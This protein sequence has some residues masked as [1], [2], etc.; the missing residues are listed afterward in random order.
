MTLCAYIR[1][2]NP[3]PFSIRFLSLCIRRKLQQCCSVGF[4]ACFF[5]CRPLG[6]LSSALLLIALT[7]LHIFCPSSS[8]CSSFL[9]SLLNPVGFGRRSETSR[10]NLQSLTQIEM[11]TQKQCRQIEVSAAKCMV[12]IFENHTRHVGHMTASLCLRVLTTP[13]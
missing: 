12:K 8:F 3:T 1:P 7:G 13:F 4:P 10:W 2:G 11:C 9:T 6:A 5:L